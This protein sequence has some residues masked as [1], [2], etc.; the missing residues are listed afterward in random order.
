LTRHIETVDR[1]S[2]YDRTTKIC[3]WLSP[4]ASG[5][6]DLNAFTPSAPQRPAGFFARLEP[7]AALVPPCPLFTYRKTR[8]RGRPLPVNIR[9]LFASVTGRIIPQAHPIG[10]RNEQGRHQGF[11]SKPAKNRAQ[12]IKYRSRV[13]GLSS[14]IIHRVVFSLTPLRVIR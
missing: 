11:I 2:S 13:E 4:T 12:T 7:P 1:G 6:S 9:E 10:T 14:Q 5:H 3:R 8:S